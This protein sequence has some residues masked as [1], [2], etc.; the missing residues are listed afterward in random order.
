MSSSVPI[1][2]I[3]E[4]ISNCLGSSEH[5]YHNLA[6]IYNYLKNSDKYQK[7]IFLNLSDKGLNQILSLMRDKNENI[8]KLSFIVLINLL[9]NNDVLQNIFCE[10][11]NFNPIGNVICINW[12]PSIFKEKVKMD[13]NLINELKRNSSMSNIQNSQT[14][15]WQCPNNSKYTDEIL[16]DPERYLLGFFYSNKSNNNIINSID[17]NNNNYDTQSIIDL[18]EENYTPSPLKLPINDIIGNSNLNKPTIS[19]SNK[20]KEEFK[21][22]KAKGASRSIDFKNMKK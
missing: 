20:I 6:K 17:V 18:L 19:Q 5:I 11:Y 22:S 15:Y 9:Y 7:D 12:L 1:K 21:K 3:C 8:R 4:E 10:K 14:K 13:I 2:T 16:P